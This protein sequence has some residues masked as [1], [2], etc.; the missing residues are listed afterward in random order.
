MVLEGGLASGVNCR[1]KR[2][3]VMLRRDNPVLNGRDVRNRPVDIGN[4]PTERPDGRIRVAVSVQQ[5]LEL[6]TSAFEKG[7]NGGS[8]AVLSQ[9]WMWCPMQREPEH[10]EDPGDVN[11]RQVHGLILI[12]AREVQEAAGNLNSPQR[13]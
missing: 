5:D 9:F 4:A 6:S 8:R 7:Q 10:V 2:Q 3:E 11:A 13:L 12:G 1:N